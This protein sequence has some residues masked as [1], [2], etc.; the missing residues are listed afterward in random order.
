[1]CS[2][3]YSTIILIEWIIQKHPHQLCKHDVWGQCG[4]MYKLQVY[5]WIIIYQ[6][7]D[8]KYRDREF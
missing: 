3:M 5:D 6:R 1:M 4:Y 8:K 2:L 7:L